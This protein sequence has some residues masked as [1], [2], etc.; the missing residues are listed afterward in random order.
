MRLGD[1]PDIYPAV[2]KKGK[3]YHLVKNQNREEWALHIS[4]I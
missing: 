4:E 3:F 2:F 1:R